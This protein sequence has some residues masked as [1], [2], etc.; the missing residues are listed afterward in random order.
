ME[1]NKKLAI[2]PL[3]SGVRNVSRS[4]FV[5]ARLSNPS[6]SVFI[7]WIHFVRFYAAAAVVILH[8]LTPLE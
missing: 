3:I 5:D 1:I 4:F 7:A 6:A 8:F 2:F